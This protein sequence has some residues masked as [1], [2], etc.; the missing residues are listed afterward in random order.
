[1]GVGG[2][3]EDFRWQTAGLGDKSCCRGRG[4]R[5]SGNSK[6]FLERL[7]KSNNIIEK[8]SLWEKLIKTGK[9]ND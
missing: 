3:E 2:E 5:R 4:G 8:F 9:E 7:N 6:V 1:M